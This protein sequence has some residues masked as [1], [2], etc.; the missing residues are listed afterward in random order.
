MKN[1]ACIELRDLEVTTQIGTY[2]ANDTVPDKHILDLTLQISSISVLIAEDRMALVFD[3][4]PLVAE[5]SRL[6]HECRYET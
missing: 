5:I 4:D 3:Y 2:D 6:A 1:Q